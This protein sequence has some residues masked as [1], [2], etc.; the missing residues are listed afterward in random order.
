MDSGSQRAFVT[1][2]FSNK[3]GLEPYGKEII[4][5]LGFGQKV[6]Q[7]IEVELV[8]VNIQLQ[9]VHENKSKCQ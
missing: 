9:D 8:E 3:L 6:A 1:R 5:I 7:S 2:K 4:S